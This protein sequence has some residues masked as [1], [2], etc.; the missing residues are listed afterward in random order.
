MEHKGFHII[1]GSL[2]PQSYLKHVIA[3]FLEA[4]F[5]SWRFIY[6]DTRNGEKQ[7]YLCNKR[8]G[9]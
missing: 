7:Y 9:E 5:A 6:Y 1:Y 8:A 3:N 2:Y 4:G